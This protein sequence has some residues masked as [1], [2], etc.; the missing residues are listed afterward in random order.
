MPC[1]ASPP[2]TLITL[3]NSLPAPP[4]VSP[5]QVVLEVAK[6][7]REDYLQQNAFSEHDYNCPLPKSIGML[8]VIV[9]LYRRCLKAVTGS[10]ATGATA[11]AAAGAKTVTWNVIKATQVK[12]IARVTDMKFLDPRTPE[13]DMRKYFGGL[14]EDINASFDAL[15][16]M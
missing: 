4:T 7:I 2:A 14:L 16:D 10:D 13:G 3:S 11:A 15:M 9:Q 1:T 8:R 12:L 6:I 5:L